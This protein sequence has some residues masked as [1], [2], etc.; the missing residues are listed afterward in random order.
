MIDASLELRQWIR[1]CD[2]PSGQLKLGDLEMLYRKSMD[3]G[4]QVDHGDSVEDLCIKVKN[5]L[6]YDLQRKSL[7]PFA[8]G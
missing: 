7:P 1:L 8:M 4:L 5:H 3:L 6:M 2:T